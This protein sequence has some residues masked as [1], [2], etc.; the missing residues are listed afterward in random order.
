MKGFTFVAEKLAWSWETT[1][2]RTLHPRY[3]IWLDIFHFFV[4]KFIFKSTL[5]TFKIEKYLCILI[6]ENGFNEV[7]NINVSSKFGFVEYFAYLW[8]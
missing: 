8:T 1:F 7:L 2:S 5:F 6:K 4:R 3:F